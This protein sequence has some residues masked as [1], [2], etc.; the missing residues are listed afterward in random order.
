MSLYQER[1]G[2][3]GFG[4]VK[5]AR[6]VSPFVGE[7][8]L[9]AQAPGIL[10]AFL[11]AIEAYRPAR[12]TPLE[13]ATLLDFGRQYH[14]TALSETFRNAGRR[15]NMEVGVSVP[16]VKVLDGGKRSVT[17]PVSSPQ[18]MAN[19]LGIVGAR[20][21][22]LGVMFDGIVILRNLNTDPLNALLVG[23]NSKTG[24][25]HFHPDFL[26]NEPRLKTI[27]QVIPQIRPHR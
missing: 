7:L 10:E 13:V 8:Q 19:L 23:I 1:H 5:E 2:L 18:L 16:T 6:K 14:R 20:E 3:P 24:Q 9:L 17:V 4:K 21:S 11:P 26:P 25:L 22:D 12:E 27:D 15:R